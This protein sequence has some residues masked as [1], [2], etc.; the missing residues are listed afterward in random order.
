MKDAKKEN[1]GEPLYFYYQQMKNQD[2]KLQLL[3][4]LNASLLNEDVLYAVPL[5]TYHSLLEFTLKAFALEKAKL[6]KTS[7]RA[8][9]SSMR[10]NAME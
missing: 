7:I 3:K 5:H 2:Q 8:S 10:G 4:S 6:E 1:I 9:S